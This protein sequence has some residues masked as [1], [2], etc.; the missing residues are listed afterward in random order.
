MARIAF[1]LV[2]VAL[3]TQADLSVHRVRACKTETNNLISH[4]D[5]KP[6][7]RPGSEPG[8]E[9]ENK[10][11]DVTDLE[12]DKTELQ[13]PPRNE[14]PT[15]DEYSHG[16]TVSVKTTAKDPEGDVLTYHYTIS[17][18]RI[19]GSGANVSWDLNR[20]VPGTYTITAAV[21]D[22]CG[23][24]GAKMTKSVVVSESSTGEP[25]CVCPDLS[26]LVSQSDA[27]GA[28]TYFAYLRGNAPKEVTCNWTISE[29]TLVSG[30]GTGS[31]QIRAPQEHT[32]RSAT[33]TVEIG[34]LD[35]NCSC[36]SSF[37][38]PY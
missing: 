13:R 22:G 5:C 25:A 6:C 26:I 4:G 21:D 20:V 37:S 16:M 3:F 1:V 15:K 11:P 29:G 12:L 35:H 38:A 17:G 34:G 2:V 10:S 18:G 30:Q 7:L 31:I 9:I 14:D 23:L 19:V 8:K 27:T 24:C 28:P 32:S 36:P 33:A